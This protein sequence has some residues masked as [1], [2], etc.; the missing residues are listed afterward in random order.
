[1]FCRGFENYVKKHDDYNFLFAQGTIYLDI[2][3][4]AVNSKSKTIKSH[5]NVGGL[6]KKES[7]LIY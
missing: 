7:I 3:E 6:P 1:M 4:S 5:H 2:I